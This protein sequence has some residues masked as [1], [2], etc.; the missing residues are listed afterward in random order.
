M[1]IE[2]ARAASKNAET[3]ASAAASNMLSSYPN[4]E[5]AEAEASIAQV[6]VLLAEHYRK[7]WV[8]Q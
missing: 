5:A 4:T 6:Y 2:A 3:H 1:S 8:G 7:M